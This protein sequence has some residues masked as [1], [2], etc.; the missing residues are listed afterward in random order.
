MA[1]GAEFKVILTIDSQGNAK[2][3]EVK[4]ALKDVDGTTQSVA[5]S[6]DAMAK[7][8][9]AAGGRLSDMAGQVSGLSGELLRLA[10]GLTA[11]YAAYRALVD[12][13]GIGM[14]VETMEVAMQVL[15]KNVGLSSDAVKYFAAEVKSAQITTMEAYGG[16]TKAMVLGLDLNKMQALATRARDIA[17][18]AG[19]N[20]SETLKAIMHGIESHNML[21][22]QNLGIA[23]RD[24]NAIFDEYAK[25]IR[26][27]KTEL[28]QV[29]KAQA[30]LNEVMRASAAYAGVA[31]AADETVGK[32]IFSMTRYAEEAKLAFWDMFSPG[33]LA[34]VGALTQGFKDMK[35]WA[36]ANSLELRLLGQGVGDWVAWAGKAALETGKW[37]TENTTLLKSLL[38]LYVIVKITYWVEGLVIALNAAAAAGT[39]LAGVVPVIATAGA[40]A[41]VYGAYKTF[42]G[43]G[44][45][46]VT[47]E[48]MWD[49]MVEEEKVGFD[50]FKK[51][52]TQHMES[53]ISGGKT[54]QLKM[55]EALGVGGIV[56]AAR[57]KVAAE[58]AAEEAARKSIGGE[59]KAGKGLEAAERGLENFLEKMK[60]EIDKARGNTIAGLQDWYTKETLTLTRL[61]D[62]T[63]ASL[64]ARG[65]LEEA[66]YARRTKITDEFLA[67][68]FK[69]WDKQPKEF[70]KNYLKSLNLEKEQYSQLASLSPILTD[71]LGYKRQA[72]ELDIKISRYAQEQKLLELEKAHIV[73]KA[74][75]DEIKGNQ[76][77]I[78]SYKRYNLEMEENQGL[79]GWA[80]SRSKEAD[81]KG[82]IKD[83]MTG[84][85]SFTQ[86]FFSSAL[87]GVLTKDKA[88]LKKI[89]ET[90]FLG[91]VGEIHKGG[92]TRAVDS[93][94]K[95]M[96]PAA[97][98]KEGDPSGAL[99]QAAGLLSG[100]GLQLAASAG[101]LLLSGIG[102]ATNSQEL[103][104]AGTVLQMAGLAIQLYA[105]LTATTTAVALGGAALSL[106]ISS[107]LLDGSAIMLGNAAIMLGAAAL[108]PG[109]HTGGIVAHQGLIV[110]H[111]G[112]DL[113]ADERL[114]K[115]QV[116]EGIL[117]V[118]AM[119]SLDRQWPGAFA[120]L[121]RGR[122]PVLATPGAVSPGGGDQI[123]NLGPIHYAP[124]YQYR[125]T[126]GEKEREA[127]DLGK[128]LERQLR[129]RGNKLGA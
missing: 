89:G 79:A 65:Y 20:T 52:Q 129:R 69:D 113:L 84:A 96:K 21:I 53:I 114:I 32:Q 59:A 43:E 58:I 91:F 66:Y 126:Q 67:K 11:A 2:I 75:A 104:I 31:A 15:A 80:W 49:F 14:K 9:G 45:P 94:A 82:T 47:G 46:P 98:G 61:E 88:T 60:A 74:Q 109:L 38:E 112:L 81:K 37:A 68:A 25:T 77:L 33:M 106:G 117:S 120:E 13:I 51:V 56:N 105:A 101:G 18:V 124:T 36:E 78:D 44:G 83:M 122:L 108:I 10:T 39:L 26:K 3:E 87:Q 28:N 63:G 35:G 107:V 42:K 102:I 121:N 90:M 72:L 4:R 73:S 16:I 93:L 71:Q 12:V 5:K 103:V 8:A 50:M 118:A 115:A 17:V 34:G 24:Q 64:T 119:S 7:A 85:E 97:P 110:A 48:S 123:I 99:N 6:A 111:G 127:R 95:I 23:M 57:A 70:E 128:R 54:W 40:A 41:G 100:S 29:E 76:A 125:L 19:K 92:I 86:N 1:A 55:S 22:F 30:M 27:T 62:K 116:G